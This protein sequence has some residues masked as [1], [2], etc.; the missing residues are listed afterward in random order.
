[1]WSLNSTHA[2]QIASQM[3]TFIRHLRKNLHVW[4]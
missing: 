1:L 4:C 2:E 3:V